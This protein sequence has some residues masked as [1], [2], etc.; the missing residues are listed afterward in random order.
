MTLDD[1]RGFVA[2]LKSDPSLAEQADDAYVAELLAVAQSAGYDLSEGELRTALDGTSG[3]IR[4][5][6]LDKVV[7]GSN[8]LTVTGSTFNTAD[9]A[10]TFN[11]VF[12]GFSGFSS[13]GFSR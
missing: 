1:V 8:F 5:D 2:K 10:A 4:S 9:A 11:T 6:E 3:E 7:G 13:K 12:G